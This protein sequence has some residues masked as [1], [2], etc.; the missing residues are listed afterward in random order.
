MR[1]LLTTGIIQTIALL[2]FSGLAAGGEFENVLAK[3]EKGDPNAQNYL[4]MMYFQ[5]RGVGQDFAKALEWF[6]K[7]AK[8]GHASAMN[9][10]GII[11][12]TGKG[13]LQNYA[14][15]MEWFTK[16]AQKDYPD[17]QYNLGLMYYHGRSDP[18]DNS[19]APQDFEKALHWFRK[20]AAL[21]HAS[22]HN[23]IGIMYFKGQ[24]VEQDFQEA[25][26]WNWLAIEM[27]NRNAL[28]MKR[29][30][31]Q[32]LSDAEI[33]A[34]KAEAQRRTQKPEPESS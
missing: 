16:S 3:A 27:G 34:A 21:G 11:Y 32:K 1:R 24:G 23:N 13:V 5:G 22:A 29:K 25:F 19:G 9:N 4:G 14:A 2:L 12:Y 31:R 10:I 20:A 30:I 8:K 18:F 26:I 33:D 17:A 7:S 28:Q 15:A 6:H